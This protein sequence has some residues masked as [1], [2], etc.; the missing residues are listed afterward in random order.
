[1][2]GLGLEEI[3]KGNKKNLHSFHNCNICSGQADATSAENSFKHEAEWKKGEK[4][5]IVSKCSSPFK[6]I[7]YFG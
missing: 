4:N 6:N 5:K 3:C 7:N 1:M 2:N